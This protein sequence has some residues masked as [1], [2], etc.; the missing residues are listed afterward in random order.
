MARPA[1]GSPQWSQVVELLHLR[2]NDAAAQLGVCTS[3]LRKLCR[4]NGLNRWPGKKMR[5]LKDKMEV[6]EKNAV[7]AQEESAQGLPRRRRLAKIRADKNKVMDK[8]MQ[9]QE[10]V[11]GAANEQQEH[12]GDEGDVASSDSLAKTDDELPAAAG[13]SS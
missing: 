6:L 10:Q 9:I 5:I 8:I 7:V 3:S 4:K 13:E 12:G 2:L 11:R 1:R